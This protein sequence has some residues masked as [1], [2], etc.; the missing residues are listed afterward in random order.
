MGD[1]ICEDSWGGGLAGICAESGE[2]LLH[3]GV[4]E[5]SGAGTT[6]RMA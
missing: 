4:D 1:S 3:P 6:L 2:M 5:E